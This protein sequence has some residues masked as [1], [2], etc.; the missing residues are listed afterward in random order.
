MLNREVGQPVAIKDEGVTVVDRAASI[1]FVG[2]GVTA[3]GVGNEG[4]STIPGGIGGGAV[5][6]ISNVATNTILGRTTAGSGDSEELTPAQT[7]T[8][9]NVEDGAT[10]DQTGAEIKTAYEAEANTNAYTDADQT[11]VGHISI[12][13]AVDLD[14]MEARVNSLDQAVVLK[15]TWD[16]FAGTFPSGTQAGFSYIVSIAGTVN[17]IVFNVNDRLI[18]ILDGA[19]TTIYAN[20]WIKADYTDQVLSVAGKTG[21]VTL[22]EADIT[23]LQAYLLNITAEPLSDLSDVTI[24]TIGAGELLKWDG[25]AWINNTLAEAGI[26]PTFTKNTAFNKNFGTAAD[27]LI[28]GNDAR[29]SDARTPLAHA[30]AAADITSGVLAHERGGIEA[31]ISTIT[32]GGLLR[33]TGAGTMGI[34][35][36]GPDTQVL[37]MVAGQAAWDV[38]AVTLINTVTLTN[39][40]INQRI[41]TIT[42]S[43]TPTPAGN[44]QDMFTVTALAV[45]ATF[46]APTGIPVQG[47]KL[48]IRI[49][50][51]GTARTLVWNAIYRAGTDVALPTTTVI[52]L[53]MYCGFIYNSINVKW[54]LVAVTDKI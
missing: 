33:G 27:T 16:A 49:K 22:V 36:A 39:K 31:D 5:D 26:E 29:L 17:G 15:G 45:N 4:T 18:S 2:A 40:R 13:Q 43:S 32:T 52:S 25:T 38:V 24:T 51:N 41:G 14:T 10:A 20:N 46:A 42:S 34:L 35:P 1:D 44:S 9:I 19:S 48:T 47:Q 11:K 23:D 53:T 54:D 3:T 37:T 28:H 12:T 8:L 7:R 30:H 50:D 21:A 6:F